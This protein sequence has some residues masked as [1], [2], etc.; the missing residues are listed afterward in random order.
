MIRD[1]IQWNV[2]FPSFYK[3][4][5]PNGAGMRVSISKAGYAVI[6]HPTEKGIAPA[7]QQVCSTSVIR[8]KQS[9]V[10]AQDL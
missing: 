6:L 3:P 9:S 2:G 8:K 7:G 5:A 10:G 4:E 1:S